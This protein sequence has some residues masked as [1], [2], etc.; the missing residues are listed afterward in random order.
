MNARLL[1]EIAAIRASSVGLARRNK[2]SWHSND[3][4]FERGEPACRELRGHFVEAVRLATLRIAPDFDFA[5]TG[6]QGEDW[7]NVNDKGGFSTPHDH[8]GWVWS[9][10]YYVR[11]PK[12][13]PERSGAIEFL[14]AFNMRFLPKPT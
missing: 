6:M 9:G 8:P 4:F 3:D 11:V 1:S 5:K 13:G 7:I 10:C 14:D 2:N 12:G